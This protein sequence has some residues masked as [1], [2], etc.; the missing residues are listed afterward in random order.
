MNIS[1]K[2]LCVYKLGLNFVH[3]CF[4]KIVTDGF[5]HK[6]F[7][8]NLKTLISNSIFIQSSVEGQK[9][10]DI[11]GYNHLKIKNFHLMS[12][13]IYAFKDY[14]KLNQTEGKRN[15]SFKESSGS[16]KYLR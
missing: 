11:G 5:Y 16:K 3:D 12:H 1:F 15:V 7:I 6:K 13:K 10:Y 9:I 8:K 2:K 4:L 14:Y